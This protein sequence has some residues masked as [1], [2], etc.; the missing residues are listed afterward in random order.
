MRILPIT[1]LASL[2]ITSAACGGGQSSPQANG[3]LTGNWQLNLV[4]N[5]PAPQTQLAASGFLVESSDGL[6]GSVVGPTIASANGTHDC[7]GVGPVTGTISE[8]N[9]TFSLSPGGTVF[10][11]TGTISSD[12]ASMA[13]S[14]QA[15]GG[16]CFVQAGTT[17]TWTASLI[18]PLN[19]SF[20]GQI[21]G[22]SYM[23]LLTGVNPPPPIAVSGSITQTTNEGGGSATLT[24]TIIAVGYPC[25]SN[26]SLTGTISGQNVYLDIY[27]YNGAFIG[28]LGQPS[29]SAGTPG[30][31][32][33]VVVSPSGISLVDTSDVGLFLGTFTGVG[34]VG[35][36]PPIF[37]AV[38][39]ATQTND[40]GSVALNLQ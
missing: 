9:V 26:G 18:P 14:Y 36:C 32:A 21:S 27:D 13:G 23:A 33:T 30:S 7:G 38:L 4:Q 12:N 15:T 1:L 19:G 35:P 34:V 16:A 40:S 29:G 39:G 28:T 25:F 6:T 31:P 24:G 11:F 2:L 20:T 10:N 22:S 17:G 37:N 5:Y 8:Q 3:P